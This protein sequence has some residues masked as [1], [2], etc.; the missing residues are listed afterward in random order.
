MRRLSQP[1]ICSP[2]TASDRLGGTTAESSCNPAPCTGCGVVVFVGHVLG[3][4]CCK[5]V[6]FFLLYSGVLCQVCAA[7][8][9]LT[10]VRVTICW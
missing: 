5:P 3:G 9:E 7:S 4:G 6:A 1:K 10:L 8:L 2:P